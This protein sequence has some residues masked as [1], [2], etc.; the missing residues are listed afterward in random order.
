MVCV[1]SVWTSQVRTLLLDI[2]DALDSHKM[3]T[4]KEDM[5][6]L[7]CLSCLE[8]M[9]KGWQ[10]AELT[11]TLDKLEKRIQHINSRRDSYP[12]STSNEG[13][14]LTWIP[15]ASVIDFSGWHDMGDDLIG[16]D[17]KVK[18]TDNLLYGEDGRRIISVFGE[19]GVGKSTFVRYTEWIKKTFEFEPCLWLN[20]RKGAR[21]NEIPFQI[22]AE[23]DRNDTLELGEL[24]VGEVKSRILQ[25]L[26]GREYLVVLDGVS[27]RSQW[28][29]IAMYLPRGIGYVILIPRCNSREFGGGDS[30]FGSSI[31]GER[32]YF[33]SVHLSGLSSNESYALLCRIVF[34]SE[35]EPEEFLQVTKEELFDVTKGNPLGILLLSGILKCNMT[36]SRWEKT[37]KHISS[38]NYVHTL[39]RVLTLSLD[40]LPR[41]LR[42]CFLYLAF[43]PNSKV[44]SAEKLCRLWIAEG[45]VQEENEEMGGNRIKEVSVSETVLELSGPK[46][47]ELSLCRDTAMKLFRIS[48]RHA[49]SSYAMMRT[50]VLTSQIR[51]WIPRY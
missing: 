38:Y 7:N 41:H 37:F 48:Q 45:F 49:G 31:S 36:I 22:L 43:L 50:D 42:P 14:V 24:S 4:G 5:K 27:G 26:E 32:D 2:E 16:L 12:S 19:V 20:L 18:I 25:R 30:S 15:T 21:D 17:A 3:L 9:K 40:D 33:S 46:R 39:E 28:N 8:L 35:K 10:V 34:R 51:Y 11:F 29:N 44:F 47:G 23:L 6:E 1:E 13:A